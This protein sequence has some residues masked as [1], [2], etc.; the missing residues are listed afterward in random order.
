MI[1]G[2][3]SGS[4]SGYVGKAP[5]LRVGVESTKS[6]RT[7]QPP[8]VH[9]LVAQCIGFVAFISAWSV[10]AQHLRASL[11]VFGARGTG[12]N[13][14]DRF[15]SQ[16]SVPIPALP[17]RS[18][19]SPKSPS[20]AGPPPADG[21]PKSNARKR[22]TFDQIT[23]MVWIRAKDDSTPETATMHSLGSFARSLFGRRRL[24][25]ATGFSCIAS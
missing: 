18:R 13:R 23:Q 16:H 2:Y 10:N 22:R 14:R 3:F 12:A 7:G 25:Q 8:G 24:I 21:P 11:P 15:G 19:F 9:G 17:A 4:Y 1:P 5:R 20:E 6:L